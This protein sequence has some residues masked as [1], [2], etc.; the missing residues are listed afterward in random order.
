M[1]QTSDTATESVAE[2]SL[3]Q[4]LG[5]YDAICAATDDLL[6]RVL[7]D[8]RINGYWKG[9]NTENKRKARQQLV[10]FMASAAGGPAFYIGADMKAAHTGMGITEADWAILVEHTTAMM[11]HLEVPD[12]EQGEILG[13]FASLKDDIVEIV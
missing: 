8:A 12:R 1:T 5:G 10:D 13:F 11:N 2:Q 9:L 7:G 3:Y 6:G 4:R